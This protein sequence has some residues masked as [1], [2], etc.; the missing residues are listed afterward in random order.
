MRKIY[1]CLFKGFV[2]GKVYFIVHEFSVFLFVY[3][4]VV[5][6]SLRTFPYFLLEVWLFVYFLACDCLVCRVALAFLEDCI[7]CGVVFVSC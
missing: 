2:T 3:G 5:M 1:Y 6:C 4:C 7:I